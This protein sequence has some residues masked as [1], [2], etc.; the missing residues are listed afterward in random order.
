[1]LRYVTRRKSSPWRQGRPPARQLTIV[2]S[3]LL[4]MVLLAALTRL[5]LGDRA[6]GARAADQRHTMLARLFAEGLNRGLVSVTESIGA[7]ARQLQAG[8]TEDDPTLL[9]LMDQALV[10]QP[11]LRALGVVDAQGVVLAS[12]VAGDRGRRISLP[13]LG[14]LP[15]IDRDVLGDLV[16]ARH[17]QDLGV[18]GPAVAAPAGVG[19]LPLLRAVQHPT[20]GVL[21]VVANLHVDWFINS[22]HVTVSDNDLALSIARYDG[23]L[24]AA[25]R[26]VPR[27]P[28]AD[29]SALPPFRDFLPRRESGT[30]RGAGLRSGTQL[31][32]FHVAASQPVVVLV[33]VV[34]SAILR[35]TESSPRPSSCISGPSP[36]PVKANV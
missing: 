30:W 19:F 16:A 18:D 25:T 7:P 6:E 4:L 14:R 24:L 26:N 13:A 1:M 21:Y 17:L 20:R 32:A 11:W 28:R 23:S 31:G 5:A 3:S 2:A 35:K 9:A 8:A 29:L 12:T 36:V 15:A 34:P 27:S 10:H 33:E 22:W